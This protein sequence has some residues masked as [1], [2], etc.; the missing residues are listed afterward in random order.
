M[1]FPSR[2]LAATTLLFAASW[3]AFTV[4]LAAIVLGLHFVGEVTRSAWEAAA[5]IPRWYMVINGAM[6]IYSFLPLYLGHGQTRRQFGVQAAV[7]ALVFVPLVSA[8]MTLGFL[9]ESGLYAL[10]D[11][12][13]ALRQTHLFAEPAQVHLVLL[14]YVVE[15]LACFAAG[16]FM[17]AGFYRWGAGG[18]LTVPFGVGLIVLGLSAG[19]SAFSVPLSSFELGL[20][21]PRGAGFA[22]L[23]AVVVFSA[24][25]ALA[26]GVIRDVPLRNKV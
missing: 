19:G 26:W 23:T 12:P 7:A 18:L 5:T 16:M 6:M 20:D 4:V 10:L 25:L 24:G 2:L 8:A 14:E 1:R 15:Y 11:R 3:G 22:A 21:L 9:L 17:G 13:Q